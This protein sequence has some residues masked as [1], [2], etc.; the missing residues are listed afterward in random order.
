VNLRGALSAAATCAAA[1]TL[2]CGCNLGQSQ[3]ALLVDTDSTTGAT[4]SLAPFTVSGPWQIKYTFDCTKENSE[5]LLNVNQ[6]TID[7]FNGDDNSTAFEHPQTTFVSVKQRGTLNFTTPGNYYL[8]IDTQC[9]WTL[10]VIDLSNGPVASASAAPKLPQPHGTVALDVTV[11]SEFGP[12][13]CDLTG[14]AA[15][16]CEV[17]DGTAG[18]SPFG[19][20]RLHRT[21]A[22]QGGTGDCTTATTTGTLTAANGDVLNVQADKGQSCKRSGVDTYPFTVAGGTGIF[23][24]ATGSGTIT[25]RRGGSDRWSG[26]I[27]FAQ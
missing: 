17:G 24:N 25:G 8:H 19:A 1:G 12:Y 18:T 13:N 4:Q 23:K 6:F 21:V 26:S 27:T 5:E 15:L 11:I 22:D 3:N 7:V 14:T 20:L 9:D 2:L 16:L 10:Q